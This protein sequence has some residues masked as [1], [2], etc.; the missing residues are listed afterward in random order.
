[1]ERLQG[2]SLRDAL[3][4]G[5]L[6]IDQLGVEGELANEGIDLPEGQGHRRPTFEI[7][8]EEAIRR[9]AEI[10]GRLCGALITAVPCFFAS[11]ST[12][13]MRRTPASPS[14]RGCDRRGC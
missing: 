4:A 1:M 3:A 6:P 13:R 14:C 11:E 2:Q 12:P 9:D 7:P 10:E 5:R 8:A